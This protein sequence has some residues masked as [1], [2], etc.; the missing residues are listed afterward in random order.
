MEYID[1]IYIINID[2]SKDRLKNMVN[3]IPIIGKPF[4]RIPAI[5]GKNLNSKE[6]NAKTNLF[7][8]T[9]CSLS[10]IGIFMSH[11]NTWE[12]ILTNNDNYALI[13]EDDS[14]L[15]PD[16]QTEVKKVLDELFIIDPDFDFVYLSCGGACDKN[17]DYNIINLFQKSQLPNVTSKINNINNKYSF[18]PE[19]PTGF[20]CYIVSNNCAKKLVQYMKTIT[21]HVDVTFL[22][23]QDKFKI[24]ASSKL[25]AYQYSSSSQSTQ[26]EEF[27]AILNKIL[28]NYKC[29]KKIA[30]SY[31]MSAPLFSIYNFNFTTYLLIIIMII[32]ILPKPFKQWFLAFIW[33]YLIIELLYNPYN[34]YY[35]IFWIIIIQTIIIIFSKNGKPFLNNKS[36]K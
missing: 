33:M 22:E 23:F 1:N 17:K 15:I 36:L 7:C 32:L 18:V 2:E 5:V 6:I 34:I 35:I 20:N 30:Y 11:Y 31:Y 24:Y 13:M 12:T 28:D 25:L 4:I 21:Y 19:T 8:R 9:F 16:F 10:M 26:T 14:E 29:K 3:Q 27:P